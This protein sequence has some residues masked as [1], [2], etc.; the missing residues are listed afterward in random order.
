[1][2]P[3]GWLEAVGFVVV[4]DHPAT[5]RLRMDL[6]STVRWRPDLAAAWSRLT[7]LV[8]QTVPPEP[9]GFEPAPRDLLTVRDGVWRTGP[10]TGH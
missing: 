7:G 6:Q 4:R 9:A 8:S 5:P 2:L 1:M 3:T 10:Y